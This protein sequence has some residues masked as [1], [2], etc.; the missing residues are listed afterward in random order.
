MPGHHISDVELQ[1]I[2]SEHP[3]ETPYETIENH[4]ASCSDCQQKLL[5]LAADDSWRKEFCSSIV[6]IEDHSAFENTDTREYGGRSSQSFSDF[7]LRNIDQMLESI[8]QPGTHPETL[9]RLGRYEVEKVIGVGGMGIV[10]RGFDREL[11]RPVAIKMIS[12][13]LVNNGTAKERFLREAKAVGALLHPNVIAIHDI[14]ETNAVPWFV[15]PLVVGP[16][17]KEVIDQNGPLPTGEVVRIGKQIAAGLAAAHQ[18]GLVHRDIKPANILVDNQIN[19]I[20][21]TDFGL[22]RREAEESMTQTGMVAGTLNYMSPE[23]SRGED[24]DARSDLFSLGS[25]LFFLTTGVTPFHSSA[26]MGVVHKLGNEPHTKIQSLN[27]AV[28]TR[29]ANMIDRLLEKSPE[30]R[31]QTAAELEEW[32]AGYLAHLNQPV[33]KQAPVLPAKPRPNFDRNAVT[34][35]IATVLGTIAAVALVFYAGT[36]FAKPTA[37]APP[38]TAQEILERHGLKSTDQFEQ[39]MN[40]LTLRIRSNEQP[41]SATT[42]NIFENDVLFDIHLEELDQRIKSLGES[43]GNE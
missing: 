23:Q 31:F 4:V 13:R 10:F 22:A 19:R 9:G 37:P 15:M 25:L 42:S 20:V 2:V 18:Q 34:R 12:P 29:L 1:R 21:I 17:L 28:P 43:L 38:P 36:R 40:Q 8:L 39:D 6:A 26:P 41:E 27:P 32:L 30:H 24:V 7:E 14:N 35:K 5:S 3:T 11:H 16:T 33:K